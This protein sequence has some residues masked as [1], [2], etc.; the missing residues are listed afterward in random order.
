MS[1]LVRRE[2]LTDQHSE[3]IRSML[4]LQPKQSFHQKK[5]K[6]KVSKP[7][8]FYKAL[9]SSHEG[10]EKVYIALPLLFA[11]KLLGKEYINANDH[12]YHR[13]ITTSYIFNGS[14]RDYQEEDVP[15]L[16]NHLMMHN[17]TTL[18]HDPGMGKTVIAAY[19]ASKLNLLTI[20]LAHRTNLLKQWKKTF[21]K[22]TDATVWIVGD[23]RIP[24]DFDVIVCLDKRVCKLD[25]Y[26][27][28]QIGTLIIDEAH[29][30]CTHSQVSRL[31][32]FHPKYIIAASATLKRDDD[33]HQMIY[34]M[35]GDHNIT[36][37]HNKSFNVYKIETSIKGKRENN[38]TGDG[39]DWNTLITSLAYNDERNKLIVEL[40]LKNPTYKIV[41]LT[42]LVEHTKLLYKV[43][44]IM[45]QSVDYLCGNKKNYRDSRIL[46]GTISKIG[47][48]FDEESFCDNFGGVKINLGII[49]HS[50]KSTSLLKQSVGRVF[51]SDF[52]NIMHLVDDD[53]TIQNHWTIAKRWYKSKGGI[54]H[55]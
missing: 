43:F 10:E 26:I 8:V 3:L 53:K 11:F 33:M 28:N 34:A 40:A 45:K 44:D 39:V 7:I 16:M 35:C 1:I 36:R 20:V 42:G 25:D 22:F 6:S 13:H 47:T 18:C 31:L 48:G 19:L 50:V 27:I 38:S 5:K 51:R 9:T 12:H 46:I 14:L 54:L 49:T 15:E 21:G 29:A 52:P 41:I 30:F 4:I 17:T 37:E 2:D 55:E 32:T 24:P 23:K